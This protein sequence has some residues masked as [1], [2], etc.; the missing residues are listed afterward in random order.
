MT[1]VLPHHH[2]N[3]NSFATNL[4]LLGNSQKKTD[5]GITDALCLFGLPTVDTHWKR[6][7]ARIAVGQVGT[8]ETQNSWQ[9]GD[10]AGPFFLSDVLNNLATLYSQKDILW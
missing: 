2:A 10:T 6:S 4:F 5:T 9:I 7:T 1:F 8:G 3:S